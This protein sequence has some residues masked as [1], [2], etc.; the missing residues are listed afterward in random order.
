MQ[1]Y[2]VPAVQM[3]EVSR[4]TCL[5]ILEALFVDHFVVLDQ[6]LPTVGKAALL[7]FSLS[8]AVVL[9]SQLASSWAK[10]VWR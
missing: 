7:T 5:F 9:T 3:F 6:G 8:L 4:T 10:A 2:Q 1:V